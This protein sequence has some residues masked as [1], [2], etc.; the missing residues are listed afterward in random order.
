MQKKI[1]NLKKCSIRHNQYES[2]KES[3]TIDFQPNNISFPPKQNIYTFDF[4][5]S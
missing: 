1:V 5:I 3:Q 2:I 4:S